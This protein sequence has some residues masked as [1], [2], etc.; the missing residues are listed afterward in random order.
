MP[1]LFSGFSMDPKMP[2]DE[3]QKMR[4]LAGGTRL[5]RRFSLQKV[6]GRGEMS[7]VWLARDHRLRRLVALKLVAD[8]VCRDPSTRENL[9]GET[10]KNL[11]LTHP[12]I[13]RVFDFVE[14][15]QAAAICL[16]YM[17]GTTLSDAREQKQS[18]CLGILELAPWIG[19]LCDALA[20][21]HESAGLIHRGL[22][23]GNLMVNSRSEIKI[24][25]FGIAASLRDSMSPERVLASIGTLNYMSPQ[26]LLGEDPSPSDDIYALGATLYEM[27]SSKPPFYSGDVA[28]QVREVTAPPISRRRVTLGIAGDPIPK[29]WED[30]IAAC[31][32]KRREGRPQSAAE[33]ARRLQLEGMI[34][35]TTAREIAKPVF[36]RY[37]KIGALAGGAAAV[38]A[39]VIYFR[40][41]SPGPGASLRSTLEKETSGNTLATS[42]KLVPTPNGDEAQTP[43]PEMENATVQ[44]ATRPPGATFAIYSGI[45]EGTTA[46]AADS[47]RRGA[48]P[49]SVPDL[50]PGRYTIFFHLQGW[51][52]ERAEITLEPGKTLPLE[53][54]FPHGS[55]TITSTPDGAEIFA[56]ETSL[57]HTPLTLDLPLGKQELTARYGSFS[58]KTRVVT[59]ES[60]APANVAFQFRARSHSPPPKPKEPQSAWGKLGNSLKKVFSSKTPPPKKKRPR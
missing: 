31:L 50:P 21:A 28:S 56:G 1:S 58:K 26:Q 12:N 27:L 57:G 24:T 59:I 52:D 11:L 16:E 35:L 10:R 54:T 4:V 32:A 37:L 36:H 51:P 18:K 2:Q 14:D 39:A 44:L 60:E 55:A 22:K 15:E 34:R 17:D 46:P 47:V 23:P 41:S 6:L 53:Y 49:G 43:R 9:K 45:V 29:H 20:Y 30:T 5:F 40:S 19:A 13:A 38:L 25:D 7:V 48:T 42:V 33:V 3:K 8:E